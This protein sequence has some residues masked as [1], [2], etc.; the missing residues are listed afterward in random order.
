[1]QAP[2]EWP[3]DPA[4]VPTKDHYRPVAFSGATLLP[5]GD[6]VLVTGGTPRDSTVVNC[7][8]C[9]QGD[10]SSSSCA[11]SQ[12]A[13]VTVPPTGSALTLAKV[14]SPLQVPRFGHTQT[15]LPDGTLL[16][17]GGLTRVGPATAAGSL[18]TFPAVAAELYNPARLSP[19][20]GDPDDPLRADL[21]AKS[22]HRDPGTGAY[23]SD[24]KSPAIL[25]PT[26]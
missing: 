23:S 14:K 11:L 15:L 8:D 13:I 25:C 7:H 4:C 19:P 1:V 16:V 6:R 2:P 21:T 17:A 24:P 18:H 10:Q 9:D 12:T 26:L 20:A 5:G 3:F 22:L